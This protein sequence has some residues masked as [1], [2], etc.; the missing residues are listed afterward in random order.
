MPPSQLK[1]LKASLREQ[2]IVGP[3]QSKKQKKQNAQNGV[4]K[5]KK[6]KRSVAL[7]EIRDQFNP[8]EIKQAKAPKF[9]VTSNKTLSGRISKGIKKPGLARGLAEENRRKT[10]LVEMQ[11][12]N[13][14]G[15][16]I[17]KRFGEND[18]SMAPEDK[19][20]ER[21]T[22]EKQWGHK[23]SSAFDLEDDEIPGEL[24]HMG[25]SLSLDGPT[26]RDDFDDD[27]LELSDADDHESDEERQARKRRRGS[28]SEGSDEEEEGTSLPERKKSKQEVM[29]ELIAKSKM[30][31]YE[32]Q[33][34][35]DDDEDLRE[36]LDK[37]MS[38]IH[39]LLRGMAPKPPPAPPADVPGMNP[40]RIAL[41]NGGDR[42]KL[43]KEYDIR[44]RQ[45]AQDKRSQPTERSK[46]E[47]EKMEQESRR[48]RELEAKRLRRMEGMA[49]DSDEEKDERKGGEDEEDE[50]EDYGLGAGIKARP[51]AAELGADDEDDFIIDDDLVASGSDLDESEDESDEQEDESDNEDDEFLKG[52]LT[53]EEAKRPEF[54]TGAN[55]PL[56]E[57]ELPAKNGVNG[58]LAYTFHCPQSHAELLEVTKGIALLDLPTVV[59]RIRAL[60]HPKLN[61]E[62]KGKLGNF[63]VSLV[64][65]I[66]YLANQSQ[67]PPFSVLENVIRHIHSLA[68]TFPLEIANAFRRQLDEINQSRALSLK[69]GDLVILTAIGTIFPT[70]DHFHQVVT[71]AILTMGRYLGQK[72]P[73]VLSDYT[74]GAYLCT[75]CL[76][77]QRLS[78]RY[79]PEV[80]SFIE[81]TLCALAPTKIPKIPGCFPYHEPKSSVRI[82]KA[83]ASDR[84]IDFYDCV[85]Q[86]LSAD[87]EESLKLALLEASIKILNASADLWTDKSA[88]T[89]VFE[90]ALTILQHLGSQSCKSKLPEST[91]TSIRKSTSKFQT[92]LRL[93]HLARRPLELHHHR[94]LAIKTSIPK[95]EDS[96]NPDKHYDPD[97]ERAETAKLRA[98]HKKEKK[99]AMRELRKDSNF[100]ARESLRQKKEKDA[101][102]EKKMKRLIA[103]IQGEE[104]KESNAYERE[105][106]WRRKGKK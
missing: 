87:D 104:G 39:E 12:R 34:A 77:Y 22:Q 7:S 58:D 75:L 5:E 32:R 19:M 97:R 66:S 50:E 18:P 14:V 6:I 84:Q 26:I 67:Q 62:N 98:E 47:D 101:A 52:L 96:Y 89:E 49:E 57:A 28:N 20:L 59:Q 48:L 76:Q 17:D 71:P 25:Q 9:E 44:M 92:M 55:A 100:I 60:Y 51:T 82:E 54:L 80:G 91:Q 86:E 13:R 79:V 11:S 31:K 106:E 42:A 30:H 1:R 21:F 38:G 24:T 4:N 93:A 64:S 35:K 40:E 36:E 41:M 56:P 73:R 53:E 83:T 78:K 99:G 45:M 103:E 33:A 61:S 94:P 88:F 10:L 46:T 69:V 15:G 81:N 85:P 90:P 43:E 63:A 8:F 102:H 16:I 72:I 74:M 105:R 65:H 29:K 3:Q 68:K 95:F 27:D 70:S 23:N 37:E 2:G